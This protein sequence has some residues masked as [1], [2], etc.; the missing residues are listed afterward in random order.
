MS[1]ITALCSKF[2]DVGSGVRLRFGQL[3]FAGSAFSV[4]AFGL[5]HRG[6]GLWG[7]SCRVIALLLRRLGFRAWGWGRGLRDTRTQ[8]VTGRLL[9]HGNSGRA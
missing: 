8:N 5:W 1:A 4:G 2:E 9:F 3:P 7:F 6:L